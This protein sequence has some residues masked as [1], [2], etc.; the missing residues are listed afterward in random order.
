MNKSKIPKIIHQIWIGPAEIPKWCAEYVV[1]VQ[2]IHEKLGWEYKFWGNDALNLYKDDKFFKKYTT[3]TD[4]FK[5]AFIADR[6][7]MLILKDYGGVYLD[8]DCKVIK[9]L[10][11]CLDKLSENTSFFCGMKDTKG[12]YSQYIETAVLGSVKNGRIPN[13]ILGLYDPLD[14][15]YVLSGGDH[16]RTILKNIDI[17]VVIFGQKSFYKIKTTNDTVVIHDELGSW[18]RSPLQLEKRGYKLN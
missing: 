12:G 11:Y 2:K 13:L 9:P 7:R 14:F 8:I 4:K 5:W 6:L 16:G 18:Y 15:K 17:D 1:E 3:N 10:D